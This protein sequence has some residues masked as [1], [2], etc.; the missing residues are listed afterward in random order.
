MPLGVR[1]GLSAAAENFITIQYGVMYGV[2]SDKYVK[3]A[4]VVKCS[5]DTAHDGAIDKFRYN[6]FLGNVWSCCRVGRTALGEH[7]CSVHG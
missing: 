5:P 4:V 6:F 1:Q 7:K 3:G 2:F